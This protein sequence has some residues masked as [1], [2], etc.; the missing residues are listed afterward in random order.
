[1]TCTRLSQGVRTEP[2]IMILVTA[3][4]IAGTIQNTASVTSSTADG[5]DTNN[6]MNCSV[7]VVEEIIDWMNYLPLI[8]R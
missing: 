2:D 8:V 4:D 7:E 3:T 1:V 6:Q 5:D